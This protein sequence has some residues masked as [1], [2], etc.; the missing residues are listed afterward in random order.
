MPRTTLTT[1]TEYSQDGDTVT[2][3]CDTACTQQR[4]T[5]RGPV[6]VTLRFYNPDTFRF[7]L[8]VNPEVRPSR[9]LPEYNE[10]DIEAAVDLTTRETDGELIVESDAL[11]VV[12]GLDDWDF[13]VEDHDGET[14]YAMQ[15]HDEDVRGN[16]RV[17]PMWVE[18]EEI[19]HGP[20]RVAK[21]G[22]AF[23]LRPTERIYGLGEKF[24]S[25]DRV[26]GAYES[27]HVEPLGTET[28][29]AYKNVPFHLST[30]GYGLL[31]DT[32]NRVSY[33][34]GL[35]TTAS[36]S[37]TVDDDT[38]AFVFFYGP[39][40]KETLDTYTAF[41]GRPPRPPKWSFGVWMSRLGYESRAQL[42]DITTRLRE[43]E[44][45]SDVVHLDPF[46]MREQQSTDLVWDTEQFPNPEEMITGLHENDFHISLW[47]HP[48]I[49][50]GTD[51]FR[52]ARDEGYFVE[53]GTGKPYV[54]DRTCQGD[55]R[56]AILDFTNPEAVEWWKDKHHTL[57]EMGVDTFKTDYGEYIPEDAV[58]ENGQTG[59]AMH[60]VY[61]YLYNQAVYEAIED[62]HGTEEAFLWGRAAWTGSQR[63]PVHWGGDPQTTINGMAAAL[64]GGLAASISGFGFWSHDIGGFQGEPDREV[65][66]RW[67]QFG[68]LSSHSRCHGTTPREPWAFGE[69]AVEIF[70]QYARLRY[71][72]MPY[73]YS[74]AE[75]AARTG[76]PVVRP[77]VLEYEDDSRTHDLDTQFLLGE[78][79]LVAPV[80]DEQ[81]TTDVYL[82]EGEWYDHW[83]GE[84][85]LGGRTVT[86]E[87]PLDTMPIFV[88]AGGLVPK[89]EA[90]Q[91][92]Q[93]GTPETLTVTTGLPAEGT[94]S[95]TF[96]FYDED[97]DDVVDIDLDTT[98]D[99]YRLTVGETAV[100]TFELVVEGVTEAPDR[101]VV[102]GTELDS[103]EW[104]LDEGTLRTVR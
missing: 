60:N 48:H 47:E 99:E 72:L 104:E 86:V 8:A 75:Q 53:D 56:G 15:T 11:Q 36:G 96:S 42:E 29:R 65:Y 103:N 24:S 35:S 1:V 28:E 89:R 57:L 52:E 38:F 92:V 37:I 59:K 16:P 88:R 46:W 82:P 95:S 20:H 27:W 6:S 102:A 81:G 70:R 21:T 83:S 33:D 5:E 100:E 22:T 17:D 45:P 51:A 101:V 44:I 49:P 90:T 32:T 85:H 7:E 10:G 87:T 91:T 19:N 94:C 30:A 80:F 31:V 73:I 98:A 74:Y 69:E 9:D 34:L 18:E 13:R 68:L 77:L 26:G 62:A 61:P 12:V 14:V 23:K 67:A 41:V 66:I 54:M 79:L 84:R 58:F 64:R 71:R 50:V 40:L 93:S 39:S 25:L 78:E 97:R 43:E 76:L 2:F 3:E 55:Y 63:Y 4:L